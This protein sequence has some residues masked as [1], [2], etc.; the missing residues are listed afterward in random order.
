MS[1]REHLKAGDISAAYADLTA[2]IRKS[3]ADAKLRVFLFQMLCVQGEWKRA[4]TQLK[5]IG[6][7]DPMALPMVQSYRE[8][9]ACEMFR[10]AVFAGEK[11]PMVFGAPEQWVALMIQALK[12]LAAGNATQAAD[13]RAEAFEAAPAS[14]GSADG[15]A[16]NWIADA[17][18]RLGPVCEIIMNGHYYWAP[19]STI[20]RLKFEDPTDLRDRVWTPAEITWANGG[21]VVAFI[22]TR[23]PGAPSTG[24]DALML[25]AETT[26]ADAGSDTFVGSGQRLL[27]TN[28]DDLPLMDIREI[29]LDN[30]VEAPT[31]DADGAG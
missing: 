24:N 14:S 29:L 2:Q 18:M 27:T 31:G 23:Y 19:Y 25:S 7:M 13:M 5:V 8:A 26:W 9:I 17:D 28:S 22:P 11:A 21:E 6:E 15:K 30:K 12:P 3:P 4:L 1:A 20:A 10:E 16:F